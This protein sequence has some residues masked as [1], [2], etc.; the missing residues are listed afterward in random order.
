MVYTR[1]ATG[2]AQ[3]PPG[4]KPPRDA[5][6]TQDYCVQ[7]ISTLGNAL[8]H[9]HRCDRRGG[10][11]RVRHDGAGRGAPSATHILDSAAGGQVLHSAPFWNGSATPAS[12]L[13]HGLCCPCFLMAAAMHQLPYHLRLFLE[14]GI[15]NSIALRQSLHRVLH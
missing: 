1:V 8:E 11:A 7:A 10:I 14:L 15:G 9:F 12:C 6:I 4:Q 3:D 13:G 2:T 5:L